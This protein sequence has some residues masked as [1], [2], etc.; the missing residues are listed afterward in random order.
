LAAILFAV[1]Y[2]DVKVYPELY[3]YE[4]MS[5]LKGKPELAK[6]FKL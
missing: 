3:T 1:A 4:I 5:R 2:I 6:G